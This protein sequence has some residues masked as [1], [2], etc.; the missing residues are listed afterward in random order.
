MD[1]RTYFNNAKGHG[2]LATSGDQGRVNSARLR[3]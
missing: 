3:L 1:L 2:V